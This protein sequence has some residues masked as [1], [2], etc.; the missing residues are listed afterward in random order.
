VNPMLGY[1]L[2]K[3]GARVFLFLPLRD[4]ALLFLPIRVAA[5]LFLLLH[6]AT[7]IFCRSLLPLVFLPLCFA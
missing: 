6:D 5:L 4:A 2:V 3:S 7:R 1:S